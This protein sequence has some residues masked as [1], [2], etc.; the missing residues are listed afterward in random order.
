MNIGKLAKVKTAENE[1]L[2]Q[3]VEATF[4]STA[5]V[6]RL[7][8]TPNGAGGFTESWDDVLTGVSCA[9]NARSGNEDLTADQPGEVTSFV[10]HFPSGTSLL[11]QDRVVIGSRTYEITCVPVPVSIEVGIPVEVRWVQ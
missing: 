3:T 7:T 4:S 8:R 11:A 6:Q 5:T 1:R 10:I 9:L 2:R